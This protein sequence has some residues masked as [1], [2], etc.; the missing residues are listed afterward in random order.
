MFLR[1]L[2]KDLKRKKTMNVIL[3]L[4]VILSAMF[5][6]SSV[7]NIVTVTGGI[8]YFF[9]KAGI[10]DV[11]YFFLTLEKGRG[12]TLTPKLE[13]EPAVTDIRT[14]RTIYSRA[15]DITLNGSKA[16]DFTNVSMIQSVG[17]TS[18]KYFDDSNDEIKDIPE[19]GIYI[20]STHPKDAGLKKGDMLEVKVGERT[21]K[22]E[23]L[24]HAKDAML[25]SSFM[26]NIR[27]LINDKV[28][29]ELL[30]DEETVMSQGAVYYVK[31]TDT[32]A[33]NEAISDDISVLFS[34][35]AS[36]IGIAYIM[37]IIVAALL[38][39]VSVCL[40]LI[41]FVV[42]RFTIGFTIAEEFREIGV[43]KAIGIK[44]RAIRLLYLTKYFGIAV[45]GA[46][47][48][49]FLGIPFGRLMLGSAE[50]SM[51]LGNDSSVLI[52]TLAAAAVVAIILLFSYSCTGKIKKLSP[53]DAVRSGQTGERFRKHSVMSL[54][55]SRL[56]AGGFLPVNDVLSQPKQ[57]GI[58]TLI[59]T[60][61]LLLIMILANTAN[62]LASDKL[63]FTLGC[64]KSDLY[65][66]CPEVMMDVMGGKTDYREYI[67]E[68]EQKLADAGIPGKILNENIFKIPV[69][70]GSVKQSVTAI[71][72]ADTDA[73]EYVYERGSAPQNAYEF[74]TT[75][76]IC[77]KFGFDIGDKVK[78]T[79]NGVSEEYLLTAVFQSMNQL[80][81]VMRLH[82]DAP[83]RYEDASS[84]FEFQINFDDHPDQ[85]TAESRKDK[86]KELLNADKVLNTA[87]FVDKSTNSSAAIAAVKNLVLI[88]S[89][90]IIVMI[91]VLME[92][93]FITKEKAEIALM[94][95]LGFKN[96]QIISHHT[97]RFAI[98]G[99]LAGVLAA[100][101]CLP[102]TKLAIDPIFGI[103]GASEGVDYEIVPFEVFVVYPLIVIAFVA[104]AA[105]LTAC[106]TRKIKASDTADIE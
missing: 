10:G 70:F 80:G 93:S 97:V 6:S 29:E 37:E 51:V 21:L 11:D 17:Q 25:G 106:Y 92:R 12:D 45:V 26:N 104:L 31:C 102:L 19:N 71:W 23:Y 1:I 95:A 96:R 38:M 18:V 53:I 69:E 50:Q 59:F 34:A 35:E 105:L 83:L 65:Y 52:G 14:E 28:F 27:L 68:S 84:A 75:P 16:M 72:C 103:M 24:G 39:I 49:Y 43:M 90:M 13:A 60:L 20:S 8:D 67:S 30:A 36:V 57:Y 78:L 98:V 99:V 77:K 81:E 89:L 61:C 42:L 56:G 82:Q 15:S 3:L 9:D 100:A 73:S 94:K 74:A 40:I 47:I 58:M 63:L 7:N 33:V 5:A 22:L 85:E 76:K 41:A 87:E 46:V 79:V 44:N 66:S 62:T 86:V 2:K 91:A 54:S 55:K 64:T 48:G 4:F 88:V 101:L 32:K